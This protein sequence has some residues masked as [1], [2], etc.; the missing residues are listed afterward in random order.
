[1]MQSASEES[2]RV[3]AALVV[4]NL[5][6]DSAARDVML[7]SLDGICVALLNLLPQME[8]HSKDGS[9]AAG[10]PRDPPPP[11]LAK[12]A[13]AIRTDRADGLTIRQFPACCPHPLR[14]DPPCA[15]GRVMSSGDTLLRLLDGED[16]MA[17]E[18]KYGVLSSLVGLL[19]DK[20][21]TL[22]QVR[23]RL[24][25]LPMLGWVSQVNQGQLKKYLPFV[26]TV[27]CSH[28]AI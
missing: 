21:K 2:L 19:T 8:E 17:A 22:Q 13:R 20:S 18:R 15:L 5:V 6:L 23:P 1:M 7:E 3:N 24:R 4:C 27:C 10:A 28:C 25:Q 26:F 9:V 11:S 16:L 12:R 14:S